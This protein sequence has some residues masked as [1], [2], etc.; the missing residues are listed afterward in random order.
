MKIGKTNA[1]FGGGVVYNFVPFVAP[2]SF[3]DPRKYADYGLTV[4]LYEKFRVYK[5]TWAGADI[6]V[7]FSDAI[8][9]VAFTNYQIPSGTKIEVFET[10]SGVETSTLIT[11]PGTHT[12][13][14]GSTK[15]YMIRR[16]NSTIFTLPIGSVWAYCFGITDLRGYISPGN[17]YLKYVFFYENTL[18]DLG[19]FSNTGILGTL[20]IPSGITSLSFLQFAYTPITKVV[21]SNNLTTINGTNGSGAFYQCTSLI[22]ADL[23]DGITSIGT[24]TFNGCTSLGAIICRAYN[25]PT[26]RSNAFR[27][28]PSTSPLITKFYV[29]NDRVDAYK[30]ATGWIGFAS[31]IY[32]IN[33]L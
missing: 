17:P 1:I 3:T 13:T 29:P 7:E 12:F 27:G 2:E 16:T 32:S 26:L 30:G 8:A 21:T 20:N 25:P 19:R 18:P 5:M 10:V 14:S 6:A 11:A 28:I 23:G 9:S 22:E 4:N 15:R 33:D 31:R 24:D